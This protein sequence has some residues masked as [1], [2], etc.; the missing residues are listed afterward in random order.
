[1]ETVPVASVTGLY[2]Q[3]SPAGADVFLDEKLVSTTPFQ[4]SEIA[5]G[6]YTIRIDMQGYRSWSMPVTIEQGVRTKISAVLER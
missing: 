1:V 6:R 5:P 3:S 2:V 4:L